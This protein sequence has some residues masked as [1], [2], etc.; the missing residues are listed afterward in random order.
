[1]FYDLRATKHSKF[2][3]KPSGSENSVEGMQTK[4]VFVFIFT[5][6]LLHFLIVMT[7][8]LHPLPPPKTTKTFGGDLERKEAS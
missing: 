1:M 8:P 7:M 4:Q 2:L 5:H 3:Q 6:P